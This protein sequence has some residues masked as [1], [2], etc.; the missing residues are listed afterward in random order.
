MGKSCHPDPRKKAFEEGFFC[1]RQA[2][3]YGRR[4]AGS[5]EVNALRLPGI[6]MGKSCHPD[7]RKKAFEE[8]FFC[9]MRYTQ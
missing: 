4:G 6:P 9:L 8:G 2:T 7:P 3:S 1:L 5:P